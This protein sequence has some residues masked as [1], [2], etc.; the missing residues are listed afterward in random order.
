MWLNGVQQPP[1]A[2]L[3]LAVPEPPQHGQAVLE[4]FQFEAEFEAVQRVWALQQGHHQA[5]QERPPVAVAV[6]A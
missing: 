4:P 3:L 5:F 2:V 1:H 6:V